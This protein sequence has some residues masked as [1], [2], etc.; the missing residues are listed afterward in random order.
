VLVLRV[1]MLGALSVREEWL[2]RRLESSETGEK[3]S[4]SLTAGSA[5][6]GRC[7]GWARECERVSCCGSLN[8]MPGGTDWDE[9]RST[10][11]ALSKA[12][13]TSISDA[14]VP[15]RY[16]APG[17]AVVLL[18][19]TFDASGGMKWFVCGAAL[20]ERGIAS[21]GRAFRLWC[22]PGV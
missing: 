1:L 2:G 9:S 7:H 15:R 12:I 5:K 21:L 6:E 3:T 14:G 11:P 13:G 16:I 4:F 18:Q 10:G 19:I 22:G 20:A 17:D 8:C